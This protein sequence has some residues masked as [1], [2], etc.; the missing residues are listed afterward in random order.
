[1]PLELTDYE[2][3]A[4]AAV[5]SFWES[6]DAAGRTQRAAGD[7]DRGERAAVTAG[8]NMDGFVRIIQDVVRA[9]GPAQTRMHVQ[10]SLATL[11]GFFRPTKTWDLLVTSGEQLVAALEFKSHVG[12]SFGNNFNNRV[13]EAIGSAHDLWTAFRDGAFGDQSRPFVGWLI[14][15]E[16]AERSRSPVRHASRHFPMF[17]EFENASYLDRYDILCRKLMRERLY[18]A[19]AVVAAPRRSAADGAYSSLSEPTGLGAFVAALAGHAAAAA[20]RPAG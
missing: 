10:R 16:D 6:R 11:P 18:S 1:M 17:P 3:N 2:R 7:V 4:R 8:K 12:P 5:R 20:A 19:A 9:N 14:L 15:V 13:E